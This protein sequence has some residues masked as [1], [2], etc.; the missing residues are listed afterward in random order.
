MVHWKAV[1]YG[2]TVELILIAGGLLVSVPENLLWAAVLT[3]LAAGIIGGF[4]AGRFVETNWLSAAFHGVVVGMI[5]GLVFI[6]ALWLSMN[7]VIPRAPYSAFWGINYFTATSG[8]FPREFVTRYDRLIA[9]G[10]AVG[11]G[12]LIAVEGVIASVAATDPPVVSTE[13]SS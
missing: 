8:V 5:G 12:L 1:T 11:G 2:A 4:V 6:P 13:A 9:L 7:Y 10:L 3:L